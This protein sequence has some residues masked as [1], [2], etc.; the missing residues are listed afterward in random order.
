MSLFVTRKLAFLAI[1]L[2]TK[3]RA[4][5]ELYKTAELGDVREH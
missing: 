3:A 2:V 5:D 1:D 4:V